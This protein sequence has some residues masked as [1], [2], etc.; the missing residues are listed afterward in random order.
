MARGHQ[1]F[2]RQE[3]NTLA[4]VDEG[5]ALVRQMKGF[6]SLYRGGNV[7][8][9]TAFQNGISEML[10]Q[11]K[12]QNTSKINYSALKSDYGGGSLV[13][14][15]STTN[16]SQTIAGRRIPH[17][18]AGL[19][20]LETSQL[21][22]VAAAITTYFEI[23]TE[24]SNGDLNRY[25]IKLAYDAGGDT[26]TPSYLDSAGSFQALTSPGDI[27]VNECFVSYKLIVDN[28]EQASPEYKRLYINQVAIDLSGIQARH[29]S[30]GG[31]KIANTK[32][33]LI[34]E[35][36]GT[37]RSSYWGLMTYSVNEPI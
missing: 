11:T 25:S 3:G 29:T 36:S 13:L 4:V 9:T 2:K 14:T 32:T 8:F 5:E 16:G 37:A 6:G 21:N 35:G 1:D 31:S 19:I 12:P 7:I 33:I 10:I 24:Y 22:P 34:H 17:N 30:P 20:G 27:A 15:C 28:T 18:Y 26:L 23:I